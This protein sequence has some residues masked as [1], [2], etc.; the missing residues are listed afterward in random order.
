MSPT[1]D[2][3]IPSA[4]PKFTALNRTDPSS[5]VLYNPFPSGGP[6]LP[7]CRSTA[8]Y[9][10][11]PRLRSELFGG[12]IIPCA[13][14]CAWFEREFGIEPKVDHSKDLTVLVHL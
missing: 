7:W 6:I 1:P 2:V 10:S 8:D 4:P 12:L 5:G 9:S 11:H 13:E 3:E 14:G